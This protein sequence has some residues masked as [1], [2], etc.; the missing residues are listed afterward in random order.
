ME[1]RDTIF[2]LE[3]RQRGLLY[4]ASRSPL[5]DRRHR[6]A[7]WRDLDLPRRHALALMLGAAGWAIYSV[8]RNY[9]TY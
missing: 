1:H 2:G 9:R 8:W 6:P 5:R 3:E 7:L 4:G